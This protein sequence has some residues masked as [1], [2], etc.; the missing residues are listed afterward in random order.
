[1]SRLRPPSEVTAAS[2]S[3]EKGYELPAEL[4]NSVFVNL[5]VEKGL[6]KKQAD[7]DHDGRVSIQEAF[8]L[9]ADRAPGLTASESN[10]P[11]HPYLAG[12]DGTAWFLDQGPAA[13]PTA[14]ARPK[15]CILMICL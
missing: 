11:Q 15:H 13:S 5:L 2:Q 1:M 6:I 7:F 4:R 9:A 14:A 8:Q 3:N 12:G 10:G